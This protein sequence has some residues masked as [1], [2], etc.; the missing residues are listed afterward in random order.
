MPDRNEI[1]LTEYTEVMNQSEEE[2]FSNRHS[3]SE[4]LTESLGFLV[5][6]LARLLRNELDARVRDYGLTPTTWTVLMAL[7]EEDRLSQTDLASRVYLDGATTTRALDLLEAR[8]LIQRIRDEDDRRVQIIHL[9]EVGRIT[10]SRLAQIGVK[11]NEQAMASLEEDEKLML[12][13]LLNR[14][15]DQMKG[16]TIAETMG[17]YPENQR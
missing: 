16:E 15:L 7:F 17:G 1:E 5:N 4:P 2:V 6:A 11:I 9:T 10:A 13:G 3:P 12:I 14:V 8:G